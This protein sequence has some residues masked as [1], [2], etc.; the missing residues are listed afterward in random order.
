MRE[1]PA[2]FV[3][4][5]L[6]LFEKFKYDRDICYLRE[7]IYEHYLHEKVNPEAFNTPYDLQAFNKSRNPP[8]FQEMIKKICEELEKMGWKTTVGHLNSSLW[9]YPPSSPPASLP[10]W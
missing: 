3:H 7:G 2:K 8:K 4:A 10:D 5:N 6:P 1:F 9:V